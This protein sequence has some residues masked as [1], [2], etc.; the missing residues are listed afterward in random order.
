MEISTE[1]RD[2]FEK[3]RLRLKNYNYFLEQKKALIA[4]SGG[5]DSTLLLNFYTYLH[6]SYQIPRP[7]VFHLDHSIR[8]NKKQELDIRQFLATNYPFKL[9]LKKKISQ[10][11]PK[12]TKKVWKKQEGTTAIDCCIRF[13]EGMIIIL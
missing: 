12:S 11:Y 3:V 10:N 13:L 9:Y 4:Y 1:T 7:G 8:D 6:L 5:K 2:I